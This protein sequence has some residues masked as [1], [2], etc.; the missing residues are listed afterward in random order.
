MNKDSKLLFEAYKTIKENKLE[1]MSPEER[2][3]YEAKLDKEEAYDA[4]LVGHNNEE[5]EVSDLVEPQTFIDQIKKDY[6]GDTSDYMTAYF[7][8]VNE[9]ERAGQMYALIYRSEKYSD[10]DRW[11]YDD[12]Q[13]LIYN[14]IDAAGKYEKSGYITDEAAKVWKE[15]AIS[16]YPD[17]NKHNNF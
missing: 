12:S 7:G 4:S 14:K 1:N 2:E 9:G 15:K 6:K 17:L 3:A 13:W 5:A 8:K 16:E 10:G 11:M